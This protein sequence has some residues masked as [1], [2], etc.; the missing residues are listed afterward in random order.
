MDHIGAYEAKTHL[1][2]LL[3]RVAAGESL[4]ITRHGRPVARLIPVDEDDRARARAAARRILE[5]RKRL[6]H[7]ASIAEL[8]ETIHEGHRY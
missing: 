4:T 5:R 6:P 7:R 3:D 2:Q 8:I 1:A